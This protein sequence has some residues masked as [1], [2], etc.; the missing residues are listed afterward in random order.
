M[1]L[2]DQ[3]SHLL[4]LAVE[5]L[6][7]AGRE[8]VGSEHDP[9]LRL[10]AEPFVTG[11]RVEL[12]DVPV[13]LGTMAVTDAVVAGQVRGRFRGR[14]QVVAGQAEV[15]RARQAAGLDLGTEL[16]RELQRAIDLLAD[17]ALDS[18]GLVQLLRDADPEAAEVLRFGQLDGLRKLDRRRIAGIPPGDD[19]VEQRAVADRLRDRPDLV[20]ARREGDD[21]VT[22]HR[23]VGRSQADD[24][25]E[26]RGLL[27]RAAGVGPERPRREAGGDRGGRPTRR[28]AGDAL[29][30]PRV[31]RRAEAGVLGR[32]A[33]GELVQVRLAEQRQARL[34]ATRRDGGVE[35]RLI[36][37]EDLRRGRRLDPA[38]GDQVLERDRNAF[39]FDLVHG[40]QERVQ[41]RIALI[42]RRAVGAVQLG[43]GDLA[44]FQ[45]SGRLLGGEAKRLDHARPSR[46][47]AGNPPGGCKST[48]T[49]TLSRPG[50]Q[51]GDASAPKT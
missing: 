23:P 24:P 22:A 8:R 48:P 10:V 25:A 14:D 49:G 33:H 46:A 41:L 43:G 47:Q 27:D 44:A 13:A 5:G 19:P 26:R 21:A 34:L 42:D 29:G 1:L 39:A 7:V 50:A 38:R 35:D 51:V 40:C 20:E 3:R 45:H 11:A 36:A 4:G 6:V 32:R 31:S 12:T 18:L 15:D 16:S 28:A 9:A 2:L 37:C 30:V 17:A